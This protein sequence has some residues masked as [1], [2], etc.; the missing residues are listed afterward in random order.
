MDGDSH[1]IDERLGGMPFAPM[2]NDV[3]GA[4]RLAAPTPA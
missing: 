3:S 2:L 1:L 4:S